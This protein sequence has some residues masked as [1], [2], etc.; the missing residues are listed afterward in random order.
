MNEISV[1]LFYGLA[2]ISLIFL[3]CALFINMDRTKSFLFLI[4]STVGFYSAGQLMLNGKVVIFYANGA[5]MLSNPV[6]STTLY[7]FFLILGVSSFFLMLYSL[8]EIYL[9]YTTEKNS[10]AFGEGL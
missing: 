6:Q 2:G 4:I 3:L 7:Y 1:S 5:Q 10:S 8:Y 9:D